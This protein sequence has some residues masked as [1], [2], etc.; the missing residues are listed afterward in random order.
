MSILNMLGRR[1]VREGV[2]IEDDGEATSFLAEQMKPILD[3]YVLLWRRLG[4]PLSA[5]AAL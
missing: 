4:L 2:P 3:A 1:P 5:G